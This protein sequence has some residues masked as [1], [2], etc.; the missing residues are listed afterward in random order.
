M[1]VSFPN[2]AIRILNQDGTVSLPWRIF[3]QNLYNSVGGE[4]GSTD[5]T[6]V[7]EAIAAAAAKAALAKANSDSAIVLSTEAQETAEQAIVFSNLAFGETGSSGTVTSVSANGTTDIGVTGSPITSSGTLNISLTNTAVTS[8]TYTDPTITVDSKGRIT[9]AV[10]NPN[11]NLFPVRY[12]KSSI[13]NATVAFDPIFISNIDVNRLIF[14]T[15][16][17][18]DGINT[19]PSNYQPWDLYYKPKS[20]TT[21]G[22]PTSTPQLDFAFPASI[23]NGATFSQLAAGT[24]TFNGQS[25]CVTA[26]FTQITTSQVMVQFFAQ[27]RPYDCVITNPTGPTYSQT[28]N[29]I[30]TVTHYID[31]QILGK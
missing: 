7:Y 25:V 22:G 13:G 12:T 20:V 21:A 5:L 3:F 8:G 27:A 16:S 9:N 2:A 17:V 24:Q 30:A 29:S 11:N 23:A 18:W 15:F 26:T 28:A 10:T 4:G 6:P 31:M 1:A 19:R 14:T